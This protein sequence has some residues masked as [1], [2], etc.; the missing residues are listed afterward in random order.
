VLWGTVLVLGLVVAGIL[1][2]KPWQTSTSSAAQPPHPPV[3]QAGTL[4]NDVSLIDAKYS[5]SAPTSGDI[6][7]GGL[8]IATTS[9]HAAKL[10]GVTVLDNGRPAALHI[11]DADVL[12]L[13][14]NQRQ[15][16]GIRPG[17]PSALGRNAGLAPLNGHP[18]TEPG[19]DAANVILG[20]HAPNGPGPWHITDITVTYRSG[21]TLWT[22]TFS[23]NLTVCA[24]GQ[25][26]CTPVGTASVAAVRGAGQS[27][28]SCA[29]T[30]TSWAGGQPV[31]A[32][33]ATDV[34][35]AW[36]ASGGTIAL[37]TSR[38][39]GFSVSTSFGFTVSVGNV[40]VSAKATFGLTLTHE[41]QTTRA[42]QYTL[43]LPPN[44]R[45][46]RATVYVYAW[47]QPATTK[48]V[49]HT[50][51]ADYTY[52]TVY[53]PDEHTDPNRDYCIKLEP[54]PGRPDLGPTCTSGSS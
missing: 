1:V 2:L 39:A 48:V 37:T 29:G 11:V 3:P 31:R 10:I 19:T 34:S 45:T 38:T 23:H 20:L 41:F 53:A 12:T 40:F 4:F 33:L 22:Q 7:D 15:A 8:V 25:G 14:R 51:D 43:T 30:T 27:A 36:Q 6:T 16:V 49:H 54:S 42:W 28:P 21:Q 24:T 13:H 50:C 17:L 9:A 44:T 26:P 35:S 52:G 32:W 18:A 5:I 47:I 46:S